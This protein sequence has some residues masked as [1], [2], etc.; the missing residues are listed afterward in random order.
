MRTWD[1]NTGELLWEKDFGSPMVSIFERRGHDIITLP[2]SSIAE[3]T[4]NLLPFLKEY[5]TLQL[6]IQYNTLFSYMY[7]F[8]VGASSAHLAKWCKIRP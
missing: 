8:A 5:D 2:F 7:I 4:F 3:S 6:V 1:R